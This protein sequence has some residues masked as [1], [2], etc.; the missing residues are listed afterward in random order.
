VTIGAAAWNL[1]RVGKSG[2]IR[3]W[4]IASFRCAAEFGRYRGIADIEK[5]APIKPD[6]S[7]RALARHG[8]APHPESLTRKVA[9]EIRDFQ[10]VIAS[11]AKQSIGRIRRCMD[12][13]V[14][15]PVIGRA[16]ARPVGSSQ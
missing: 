1:Q 16:F 2:Q 12:C 10:T 4:H 9:N 8:M 13:F 15:E 14:A 11:A 5:A 6:L 7:V 3:K